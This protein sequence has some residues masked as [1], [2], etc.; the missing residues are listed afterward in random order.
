MKIKGLITAMVTPLDENGI[1]EAATCR[2]VNRLIEKGVDG[3]F[4]LGTNG[5]FYAL[6]KEEKEKL[7]ALVVKEARG[8]VPVF[9]GSGGISTAEVIANSNRFAELGIDA[10]SIITPFLVALSD[11]EL[12]NHYEQIAHAL[13]LP[14]ILYNIPANTGNNI[15]E[16][17]YQ[18]LLEI[19]SIIAIKDSSGDLQQ[20]KA[21]IENNYRDDFAVL[22][23]S[24]SK[25]LAGL[26][27][28]ADGAVAATSNVLTR[29]DVGIYNSFMN[30]ELEKA[31]K[32]Q[33]SIE[34]FRRLLK[35]S[36]VPSVLKYSMNLIGYQVGSPKL[37]V[38][39]PPAEF[40]DEIKKILNTY[41]AVEKLEFTKE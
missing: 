5:E 13:S 25:I 41:K 2:L 28:G 6:S 15:S 3:L 4:I 16:N 8:R 37:P 11:R 29:T 27:L 40:H 39:P 10:V 19:P 20:L 7:V 9:A 12:I 34:D 30:N 14:I 22:V 23:G 32:L 26:Q 1:N 31:L 17:V 33:N 18:K 36:T 24:D 35:L 38:L 21:Y